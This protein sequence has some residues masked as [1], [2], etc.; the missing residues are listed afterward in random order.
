[1]RSINAPFPVQLVQNNKYVSFDFETDN[2]FQVVPLTGV[3]TGSRFP[4]GPATPLGI[5]EGD[6]LVIDTVNFNGRTKVDPSAIP[7]AI[8]C[9]SRSAGRA[10]IWPHDSGDYY[11]RPKA[12]YQAVEKIPAHT[13]RPD[14]EIMEF[15]CEENNKSLW[16]G[17]IKAPKF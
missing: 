14:W 13:L 3:R 8:S 2:W 10:R 6:T 7:T 11:R 15:S 4:L 1:M 12:I 16:E 9:M 5:G 17:R